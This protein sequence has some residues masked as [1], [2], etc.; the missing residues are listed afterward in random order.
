MEPDL[1]T[2]GIIVVDAPGS[3]VTPAQ[4][5]VRSKRGR[6]RTDGATT[7]HLLSLVGAFAF[8]AWL[9]R[10]LWFFGDEWDFLVTRGLRYGPTNPESIWYPHNEHWSTLPVLLWRGLFSVFHLSTYWPYIVPVLL[11]QLGVMHLSWRLCRRAGVDA[12]VATAAVALLG[13]LGAGAE[14]LTWGFQIGFVGSVLFGLLAF[15]L[16][17]RPSTGQR[18]R[19]YETFAS[20]A[21]LASLMCSTIGDA[22]VVGA[23]VLVFARRPK[24]D[25][26]R[27]LTL[28][29]AAYAVWFMF[30]GHLGLTEHSDQFPLAAFTGAPSYV[31]TGLST[32]LGQTLN[33]E[34]AGAALLV[35]LGAWVA[36]N[37]RGLWRQNPALIGLCAAAVAFYVLTALGR[38]AST[39]S[40][41]LS[42]YVYV[43]IA[44]LLPTLAKLLSPARGSNA[45]RWA[46][47]SLLAFT[48]LGNVGQAQSWASSRVTFTS[49]LKTDMLAVGKLLGSGV[50]DVSGPGA[51][52]INFFPN[53]SASSLLHLQRS[54][55]L[56]RTSITP[57]ELVNARTLL[58]IGS[59]NGSATSL[60]SQPLFTGHFV[61]E[62]ASFALA[63]REPGHC[64]VFVPKV[65][66]P[67]MQI[68]LRIAPGAQAAS[69]QVTVPPATA[70]STQYLAGVLVPKVAPS[71]SVA[72][73]LA[74]PANGTGY[75]SDNDPG[76]QLVITWVAG[77][78]LTLCGITV[79]GKDLGRAGAGAAASRRAS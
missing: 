71:S 29:V 74:V 48:A 10:G 65:I 55:L 49:R 1:G 17:D 51:A 12:W 22:M 54:G 67:P 72:A 66:S 13:V 42:R 19:R 47:V 76:A 20:L 18:A 33:L 52:P 38:D 63:S 41:G 77:N 21:L 30:V 24:R 57:L 15:D 59:W 73:E 68:W 3:G 26:V 56:P 28:P 5:P 46:A 50:R 23:A 61:Y 70:G 58:A 14:D 40:P 25:A 11:A 27:V 78:P 44:L 35:G 79:A 4:L 16:L 34:D 62:K 8:W 7:V 31:W 32:A 69:A 6:P 37:G 75:L 9:D 2:A 64:M 43:A 60:T 39:V 53:L 45:A 36:W